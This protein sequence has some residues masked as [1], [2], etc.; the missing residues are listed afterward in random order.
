M[1][2]ED[3]RRGMVFRPR[4]VTL[5]CGA[6]LRFPTVADPSPQL[7]MAITDRIWPFVE[8]QWVALGGEPGL[9]EA[10][11]AGGETSPTGLEAA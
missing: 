6:P 7:A 10:P 11:L 8:R 1:G 5:S 4:R 2:T 9:R 3:V